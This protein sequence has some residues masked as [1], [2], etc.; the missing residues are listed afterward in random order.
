M[1]ALRLVATVWFWLLFMGLPVLWLPVSA[2]LLALTG[3]WDRSRRFVYWWCILV[4]RL[5][6]WL[7]P[8]WRVRVEGRVSPG[9]P[10]IIVANHA[11]NLDPVVLVQLPLQISFIAKRSILR[12]PIFGWQSAWAG[13]IGVDR[14][15]RESGQQALSRSAEALRDGRNVGVFAEG[16]RSATG[17]L[18]PF[19]SGAFRLAAETKAPILPVAI[20]GS[21]PMLPKGSALVDRGSITLRVL[22]PIAP[23]EATPDELSART[24]AAIAA[25]LS[26]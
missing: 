17:E 6:V 4:P 23:G 1:I 12:I 11:S 15:S 21:R 20:L 9:G 19:K 10:F 13:M 2:V 7:A 5:S 14:S 22:E 26:R 16:T 3:W 8:L 25:A 24:R 18:Q